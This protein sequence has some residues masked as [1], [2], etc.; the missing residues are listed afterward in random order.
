MDSLPPFS[1]PLSPLLSSTCRLSLL[2]EE[3]ALVMTCPTQDADSD[4]P[5]RQL[6]DFLFHDV[7]GSPAP[8][9]A[10]AAL[11]DGLF[12]TAVVLPEKSQPRATLVSEWP[13]T[14]NQLIEGTTVCGTMKLLSKIGC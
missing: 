14:L 1:S 10:M 4:P 8:L 12:V 11:A 2:P 6:V 3:T 13:C 9:E 7:D 5:T